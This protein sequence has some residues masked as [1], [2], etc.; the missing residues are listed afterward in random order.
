MV[1]DGQTLQGI[2]NTRLIH[3]WRIIFYYKNILLCKLSP[4]AMA[5][6]APFTSSPQAPVCCTVPA[7][8]SNFGLW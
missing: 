1:P 6:P 3:N 4:M 7:S 5:P 8:P 2:R